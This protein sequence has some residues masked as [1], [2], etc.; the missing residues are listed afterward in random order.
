[1]DGFSDPYVKLK[2]GNQLKQKTKVVKK[3]LNPE[4]NQEF[5]FPVWGSSEKLI[6]SVWDW[7][8]VAKKV[9]IGQVIF[10]HP[11]QGVLN[12][13]FPLV[14]VKGEQVG[15]T[16]EASIT[17]EYLQGMEHRVTKERTSSTADQ[18]RSRLNV[19]TRD[20][21]TRR[22]SSEMSPES[23]FDQK[24]GT[25]KS[26]A[27]NLSPSSISDP[28]VII[29]VDEERTMSAKSFRARERDVE[30]EREREKEQLKL[31]KEK[32]K[33][34][35]RIREKEREEDRKRLEE[36]DQRFARLEAEYKKQEGDLKRQSGAIESLEKE[37]AEL[38]QTVNAL[39][40]WSNE[41]KAHAANA[42]CCSWFVKLFPCCFTSKQ[43]A[44]SK[45]EI[46]QLED[47]HNYSGQRTHGSV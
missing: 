42:G 32:E 36:M 5:R 8:R 16:M 31:E 43:R 28:P 20:S 26:G 30:S 19:H 11:D 13:S 9:F 12:G 35:D 3:T 10:S 34:R 37:A 2:L 45:K 29:S 47:D 14:D 23:G 1:M 21:N 7:N 24:S 4:F 6:A 41:G 18:S 22:S 39:E 46:I 40:A 15:G 25:P 27:S 38:R 33:E 17:S 44:V